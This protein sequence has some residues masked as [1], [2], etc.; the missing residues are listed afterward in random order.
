[1]SGK[2]YI[3]DMDSLPPVENAVGEPERPT[4]D[5]LPPEVRQR[6]A[7]FRRVVGAFLGIAAIFFVTGVSKQILASKARSQAW[8][9]PATAAAN[10]M[11]AAQPAQTKPLTAPDLKPAAPPP[12]VANSQAQAIPA[13]VQPEPVAT[14]PSAPQSPIAQSPNDDPSRTEQPAVDPAEA[15][16]LSKEAES[17][18]NRG[19]MGAAIETSRAAIA[20]DPSQALPYLLLGSALQSSG[21]WKD[22]IEAYCECVRHAT[23]GPV[24]ECRAVGGHK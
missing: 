6:R 18:L 17:L 5:D 8:I 10:R 23:H 1:V 14:P 24:A 15:T 12:A 16:R 22:G 2:F 7:R 21:K 11:A 19:K 20:A 9:Q 13:E 4:V 3:P